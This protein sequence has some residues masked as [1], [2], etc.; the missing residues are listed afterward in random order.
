MKRA[1]ILNE[2]QNIRSEILE[3]QKQIDKIVYKLYNLDEREIKIV[4]SEINMKK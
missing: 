3:L 1:N 4:E 2:V